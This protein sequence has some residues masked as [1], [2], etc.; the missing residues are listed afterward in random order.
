MEPEGSRP[1][2]QVP[3]T[4][5]YPE[6]DQSGP[7]LPYHNSWRSILILFSH[8]RLGIPSG[9]FSSIFP[10]KTLYTPLLSTL[11]A[12]CPSHLILLDLITRII[13]GEEYRSWSYSLCSL[14]H[15]PVTWSLVG[16]NIVL[17]IPFSNILSLCPSLNLKDH[18]S[19]PHKTTGKIIF[20]YILIFTFMDS[21]MEDKGLS[22]E[23]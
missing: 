15:S 3:A 12:I 23:W 9:L 13:L 8:L 18:V 6:P 14:L 16:P 19:H 20:L 5:P 1:R 11:R 10:I 17:S 7:Y 22:T 2:L 21:A 4:C